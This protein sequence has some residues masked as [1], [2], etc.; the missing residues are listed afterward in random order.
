MRTGRF[1]LA[2]GLPPRPGDPATRTL[3]CTGRPFRQWLQAAGGQTDNA[4]GPLTHMHRRRRAV[5]GIDDDLNGDL[6]CCLPLSLTSGAD[7]QGV[8]GIVEGGAVELVQASQLQQPGQFLAVVAQ[9]LADGSVAWPGPADDGRDVRAGRCAAL[10]A[11][12]Q[13]NPDRAGYRHGTEAGPATLD[14]H[15]VPVTRPRG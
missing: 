11:G 10:R 7:A 13:H 15:R 4:P 8:Q 2:A 14:G 12:R 1:G 9:G 5:L 6:H 3:L